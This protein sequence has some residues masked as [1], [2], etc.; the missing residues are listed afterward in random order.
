[1]KT[2]PPQNAL[3]VASGLLQA[4][5]GPDAFPAATESPIVIVV[6]VPIPVSVRVKLHAG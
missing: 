5:I 3:K 4:H 6:D 2:A 1:V